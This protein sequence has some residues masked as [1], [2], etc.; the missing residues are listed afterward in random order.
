M[1]KQLT[2][3]TTVTSQDIFSSMAVYFLSNSSVSVGVPGL[4]PLTCHDVPLLLGGSYTIMYYRNLKHNKHAA[5]GQIFLAKI[6]ASYVHL[7]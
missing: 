3:C 2:L 4:S 7:P 6:L 5:D 1:V